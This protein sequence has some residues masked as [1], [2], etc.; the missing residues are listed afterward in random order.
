[1][2]VL[3]ASVVLL[4]AV[5]CAVLAAVVPGGPENRKQLLLLHVVSTV[6]FHIFA[7]IDYDIFKRSLLNYIEKFFYFGVQ[8]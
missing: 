6:L 7:I 8:C 4:A 5:L 3:L 1:M 2:K